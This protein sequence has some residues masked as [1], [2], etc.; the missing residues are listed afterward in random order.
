MHLYTSVIR[1][2]TF[3]TYIALLLFI[4]SIFSKVS[5]YFMCTA[6]NVRRWVLLMILLTFTM[7]DIYNETSIAYELKIC[8]SALLL[9]RCS[10]GEKKNINLLS[11]VITNNLT[12]FHDF[13]AVPFISTHKLCLPFT[14]RNIT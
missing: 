12:C 14:P 11:I 1:C 9:Y 10:R 4:D 7:I 5:S 8:F 3:C 2:Y 13:I 6:R